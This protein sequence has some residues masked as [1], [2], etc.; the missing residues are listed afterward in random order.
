[1]HT[2]IL[3]SVSIQGGRSECGP[4]ITKSCPS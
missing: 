3:V 2:G 1:V 4:S